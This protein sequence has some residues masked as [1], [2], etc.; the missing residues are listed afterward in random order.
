MLQSLGCTSS[1]DLTEK[2][3]P[4]TIR[5]HGEL[6]TP[7]AKTERQAL[8]ELRSRALRLTYQVR[9]HEPEGRLVAEASTLLIP[10]DPN[11]RAVRLPEPGE[12]G[13]PQ[14]AAG[15]PPAQ[16]G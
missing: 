6:K 9:L 4:K 8:A 3:I 1:D 10:T 12:R 7:K 15:P 14:E 2:A 16:D 13:L 11:G 5:W